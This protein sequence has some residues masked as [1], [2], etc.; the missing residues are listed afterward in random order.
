MNNSITIRPA[1][2]WYLVSVLVFVLGLGI[3]IWLI[4]SGAGNL[5]QGAQ[6]IRG[7]GMVELDQP[8]AYAVLVS[9]GASQRMDSGAA[10]AWNDA[11]SAQVVVRDEQAGTEIPVRSVYETMDLQNT[12]MARLVE[13]DVPSPGRYVVQITPPLAELKPAVRRSVPL[14][15]VQQEVMG[16]VVRLLAGVAIGGLGAVIAMVIF[17]VV[18]VRRSR[19]KSRIQG[20]VPSPS[21]STVT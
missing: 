21:R 13:F 5:R 19:C 12:L 2:Y 17:V 1:P 6:P 8:G 9:R 11:R 20:A 7:Q 10:R 14:A 16:F 4:R 15:H 18:V 3:A